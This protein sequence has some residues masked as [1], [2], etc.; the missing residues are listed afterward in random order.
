MNSVEHGL[1]SYRTHD[2][3]TKPQPSAHPLDV[4]SSILFDIKS[5]NRQQSNESSKGRNEKNQQDDF[6]EVL[7]KEMAK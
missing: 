3:R 5:E 1:R 6:R 4:L 7:K 2:V